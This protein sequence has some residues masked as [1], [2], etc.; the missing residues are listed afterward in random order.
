MAT[1]LGASYTFDVVSIRTSFMK[2]NGP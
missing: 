2:I 1:Y